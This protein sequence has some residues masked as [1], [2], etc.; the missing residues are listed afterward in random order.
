MDAKAARVLYVN[1]KKLRVPVRMGARPSINKL[2][3]EGMKWL[4]RAC[5]VYWFILFCGFVFFEYDPD[6]FTIGCALLGTVLSFVQVA[7]S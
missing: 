3:G 4:F 1:R 6:R 7:E 5:A 2:G